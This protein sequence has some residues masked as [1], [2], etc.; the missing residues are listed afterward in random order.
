MIPEK[1]CDIIKFKAGEKRKAVS[2][3]ITGTCEHDINLESIV[4]TKTNVVC[5]KVYTIDNLNAIL[6]GTTENQDIKYLLNF[7]DRRRKDRLGNATHFREL[8]SG[9]D[10]DCEFMKNKEVIIKLQE[11]TI[12]T[13]KTISDI[14]LKRFRNEMPYRCHPE[15]TIEVLDLW[16]KLHPDF[17]NILC[18]LQECEPVPGSGNRC[19]V[20]NFDKTFSYRHSFPFQKNVWEVLQEHIRKSNWNDVGVILGMD[21]IHPWQCLA[22][23]DWINNQPL[24]EY[25]TANSK[26]DRLLH[27]ALRED[28]YMTF[29]SPLKRY[30]DMVAHRFIEALLSDEKQSPYTKCEIDR[31]CSEMNDALL[32]QKQFHNGCKILICGHE[33]KKQPQLFNGFVHEVSNLDIIMCYPSLHKLP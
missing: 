20:F 19:S 29:T 30:I 1:L 17:G 32:R 2:L 16:N 21:E 11:I 25:R 18:R 6:E 12:F 10:N 28:H 15:P 4:L 23:E 33:L 13:N 24:A 27:F 31:I 22:S 26:T 7:A 14:L 9:L 3:S 8:D 5:Q